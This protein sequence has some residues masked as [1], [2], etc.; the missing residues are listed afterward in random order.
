MVKM[1]FYK[2]KISVGIHSDSA[3]T[4]YFT[5][6]T[7]STTVHAP[8]TAARHGSD[9]RIPL[10]PTSGGTASNLCCNC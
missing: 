3:N 2:K 10:R 4:K 8:G 6:P 7:V 5:N 1:I 9:V